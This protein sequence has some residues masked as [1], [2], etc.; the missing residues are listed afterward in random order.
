MNDYEIY[1]EELSE[2]VRKNDDELRRQLVDLG[3]YLATSQQKNLAETPLSE[4]LK[5]ARAL[6]E[7]LSDTQKRI[8]TVKTMTHGLSEIKEKLK[9]MQRQSAMIERENEQLYEKIG[10]S[11]YLTYIQTPSLDEQVAAIFSELIEH[12]REIDDLD[13]EIER[14]RK[15]SNEKTI[16]K[17]IADQG[18]VA[19][20]LSRKTLMLKMLP[21]L[22]R[23]VGKEVALSG[24]DDFVRTGSL[25][26]SAQSY[27][28]NKTRSQDLEQ[29]RET[30][31]NEQEELQRKL[32]EWD[33]DKNPDQRIREWG[34]RIQEIQEKQEEA[35]M[36]LGKK[37][38]H[39]PVETLTQESDIEERCK[40]I[41]SLEQ[42]ISRSKKH[43]AR[44]NAALE[45]DRLLGRM[46]Q[47]RR[48]IEDSE[49]EIKRQQERIS[50][51]QARI[52]ELGKELSRLEKTRGSKLSLL[53]RKSSD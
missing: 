16:F 28:Q 47:M 45:I 35:L 3:R 33:A 50:M 6:T 11:A 20:N 37:F 8:D 31:L 46:E 53:N 1:I 12:R 51:L 7:Q 43:I 32:T 10:E 40:R 41:L 26:A 27:T 38:T 22:Y 5:E 52:E 30:L 25:S 49:A 9:E 24:M 2:S 42:E 34:R 29:K 23:R 19:Y 39:R 44:L 13:K 48:D 17:R 4:L 14:K 15:T 18:R 36:A 21:K